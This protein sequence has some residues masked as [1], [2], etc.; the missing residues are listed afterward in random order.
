MRARFIWANGDH[1]TQE[2]EG[3]TKLPLNWTLVKFQGKA[4]PVGE[5]RPPNVLVSRVQFQL[6]RE[7]DGTLVYREVVSAVGTH[8]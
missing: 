3:V 5:L 2:L 6:F 7:D 1:Q 8:L 4:I